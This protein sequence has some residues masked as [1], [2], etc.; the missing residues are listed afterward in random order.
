VPASLPRKLKTFPI[1]KIVFRASLHALSMSVLIPAIIVGGTIVATR[2]VKE[3]N[4]GKDYVL[5]SGTGSMYPTFPKG[6]GKTIDEQSKE[7][8]STPGM[9]RYPRG[10]TIGQFDLLTYEIK[11]G[12]IVSFK[13]EVTDA[14]TQELTGRPASFVKR[15][16]GLAGD[17]IE[18]RSGIL[19]LNEEPQKE[20]YI[21][22]P[23][24]T[25]GG[26][27]IP[28]CTKVL[29]PDNH[30]FVLGDNRKGSNDSRNAIGFV[31]Q[32][33][34]HHVIPFV[35][36]IGV[37]DGNWRTTDNDLEESSVITLSIENYVQLLNNERQRNGLKPLTLQPKLNLSAELRGKKIIETNDFSPEATKSGYPM[38][39]AVADAGYS[40]IT[41]GESIVQ[42]Y[43]EAQELLDQQLVFPD[44]K[45]FLLSAEY[46]HIGVAA[47]E[48]EIN[49]CPTQVIVRHFA[50]YVPPDYDVAVI[51]SWERSLARLREIQP[52]WEA[53]VTFGETYEQNKS[54]FDRVRA[55]ISERISKQQ[56]IVSTMRSNQW[57]PA[58][59]EEYMRTGDT[60]LA[61]E[62]LQLSTTVQDS[63][64]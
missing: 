42:G 63:V 54:S 53:A 29:V 28:E 17:T 39:R 14:L 36:Q 8:V 60:I 11:R 49:G 1:F 4:I 33:D 57:L 34:I 18:L 24:S 7:I 23:R 62:Q 6:E 15:V 20:P 26:D 44:S 13:N 30:V 37:L 64:Q 47:V 48:G 38:R 19:Y 55:I 5:I 58:D 9:I 10:T 25:F 43:Y 59:L 40:N 16:I 41:Y 50:G 45:A 32:N 22:R 51:E 35:E 27:F 31:N 61:K 21:A 56:Q 3:L 2:I 12:D 46:Q 52:S